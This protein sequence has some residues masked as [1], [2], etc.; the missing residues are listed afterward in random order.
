MAK[1]FQVDTGGSLTTS[2]VSY[3]KLEDVNDYFGVKN[4]TNFGTTI[5]SSGKVNNCAVFD[6]TS[7]HLAL[8]APLSNVQD[9]VS[10][11]AWVYISGSS[12]K[13]CFF[14]NG[15]ADGT[16]GYALGVGSGDLDTLGNHLIGVCW[17]VAWMDFGTNI[18]T[19]WHLVG[20]IRSSGTWTGYVDG[21]AGG[22]TFSSTPIT[23]TTNFD[24]GRE[25]I[26][27]GGRYFGGK[28]DEFGFWTKALSS[29]E[30]TDL[31][32][33]GSGQTMVDVTSPTVTTQNNLAML[34]V[35]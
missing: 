13:G 15:K 30:R 19:G 2:L 5:F 25:G 34:G 11:F 33:S 6:G 22:T 17:G 21:T 12:L 35:S 16:N 3:Y 8:S 23:P 14:Q 32:N 7:Q 9:N 27:N 24:L 10:I 1:H 18:G 29:T 31:Y 28:I 26:D 4:L 20:M